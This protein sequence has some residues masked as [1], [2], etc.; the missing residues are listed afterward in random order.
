MITWTLQ[1]SNMASFEIPLGPGGFNEQ[2]ISEW[3][4]WPC[5]LPKG[6]NVSVVEGKVNTKTINKNLLCGCKVTMFSFFAS[7]QSIG[8]RNNFLYFLVKE[9]CWVE[10]RQSTESSIWIVYEICSAFSGF[11]LAQIGRKN[12]VHRIFWLISP[13]KSTGFPPKFSSGKTSAINLAFLPGLKSLKW[14]DLAWWCQGQGEF[15]TSLRWCLSS[16]TISFSRQQL[17]RGLL[18]FHGSAW[19]ISHPVVP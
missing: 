8:A 17:V 9:D 1:S 3:E 5:W 11:S 4:F 6:I 14:D 19:W 10:N 16:P 13:L 2:I 18:F 15:Y 12:L 7:N